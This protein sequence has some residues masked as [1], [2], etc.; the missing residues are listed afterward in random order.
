M[1]IYTDMAGTVARWA[2]PDGPL[3]VLVPEWYD[4]AT[5]TATVGEAA[6]TATIDP[7][8]LA[9]LAGSEV[10]EL[11]PEVGVARMQ[12]TGDGGAALGTTPVERVGNRYCT[13][14][15]VLGY[16]YRNGDEFRELPPQAIPAAIQAAEEAIEQACRRSFCERALDVR[17]RGCYVLEELPEQDVRH[18]EG[19]V[20]LGD[21]QARVK[22]P[23]EHRMVYGAFTDAQIRGAAV[24]L[25]CFYLRR[26]AV[27]ENARG[28]SMDGV[29]V[30]YTLATGEDGSWTGIPYVDAVIEEH[31]S[32]RRIVR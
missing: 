23:G 5:A 32:H 20:L 22:E 31:R 2:V 21:R 28:Q 18:I 19:G 27:A 11:I 12:W 4:G 17:M 26:R 3:A 24:R 25:A 7:D 15:D 1:S 30:S 16:G 8:R 6:V 13:R 29:Y 14:G 10:E 9:W